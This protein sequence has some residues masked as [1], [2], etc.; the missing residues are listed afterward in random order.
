MTQKKTATTGA[1]S[2]EELQNE[3]KA[4]AEI[5]YAER[6]AKNQAGDELSDWLK[7]EVK[8]KAKYKL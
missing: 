6:Q 8:V 1:P 4:A 3:I 7:A 2:L 5:I